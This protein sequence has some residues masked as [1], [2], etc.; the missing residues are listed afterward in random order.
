MLH[1]V[2]PT[3]A[4][5]LSTPSPPDCQG[6]LQT[7]PTGHI[8]LGLGQEGGL[9]VI[10]PSPNHFSPSFQE[11]P[12]HYWLRKLIGYKYPKLRTKR[13]W[14]RGRW[15]SAWTQRLAAGLSPS[16]PF[17]LGEG[18]TLPPEPQGQ[19]GV[20]LLKRPSSFFPGKRDQEKRAQVWGALATGQ[21]SGSSVA[22]G[23][24]GRPEGQGA[25]AVGLPSLAL[26]VCK[27]HHEASTF[28][29]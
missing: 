3:G 10:C 12:N 25:A 11:T 28:L 16:L 21:R 8:S 23:P 5:Q 6:A 20:R 9:G 2:T 29:T 27:V 7:Q 13:G 1:S 14:G 19:A 26:P 15:H 18:P 24:A 17:L 22:V 4:S